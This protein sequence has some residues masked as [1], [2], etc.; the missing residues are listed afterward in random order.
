MNLS[1]KQILLLIIAGLVLATL[2]AYEPVRKNGFI[3]FDD[4]VYI[5]DNPHVNKGMT[6]DSVIWAFTKQYT[7]NW[8]PLTWL[9]HMLDCQL[10]GLNPIGH[11]LV[12]LLFHIANT[13]LLFWVLERMTGA[14]WASA[15]VAAVFALHPVHVE[16]VAWAAERKD[17]LSGFFWMLTMLAYVR[18]AEQPTIKRYIIVLLAFIMAMMS[19]PMAVTLPFVLLLLDYWPLERLN[20]IGRQETTLPSVPLGR[21]LIEKIPLIGLSAIL[22]AITFVVQQRG[23]AVIALEK[24]PLDY[25]IANMFISYI[26]YIGK[27]IWPSRL[28]VFYPHPHIALSEVATVICALL[29][30]MIT[31]F[32]IEIGRRRKYAVVG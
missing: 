19:K 17:V 26:R 1:Q 14:T 9:S 28:A 13:L 29:V 2:V 4:F 23:G 27:T 21:L 31:I 7:A 18:Y 15:F 12:S 24:I 10:F 3:G 22:S 32:S 30:V 25:R 8:H 11:H 20:R 16:S 5:I 6:G